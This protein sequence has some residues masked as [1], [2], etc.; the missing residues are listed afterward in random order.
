MQS[1]LEEMWYGNVEPSMECRN[2]SKEVKAL[3]GHIADHYDNLYKTLAEQQKEIFEK[4]DDCQSEL[5]D[6]NERDIFIYGF[7]LG[8]RIA[9]E[10]LCTDIV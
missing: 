2:T 5:T 10:V 9:M 7:R 1:V 8:A 6:I 4:F 3:M